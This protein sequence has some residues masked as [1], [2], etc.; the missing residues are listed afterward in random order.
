MCA[1]GVVTKFI[2]SFSPNVLT[3]WHGAV[4][5]VPGEGVWQKVGRAVV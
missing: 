2:N 1:G 5:R 3:V 4:W